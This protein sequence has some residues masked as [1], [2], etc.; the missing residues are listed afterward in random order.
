MPVP[1]GVDVTRVPW[2]NEMLQAL[3]NIDTTIPDRA[4]GDR[5]KSGRIP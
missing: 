3:L 4:E 1:P 5:P 2:D